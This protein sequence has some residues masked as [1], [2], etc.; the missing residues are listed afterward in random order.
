MKSEW[1]CEREEN[2]L[3]ASASEMHFMNLSSSSTHKSRDFL[4]K[5]DISEEYLAIKNRLEK[6]YANDFAE[7]EKLL[8]YLTQLTDFS[9]GRFLIKN[10][11][12]L[13][14]YWTYYAI[15]GFAYEEQLHSLEEKIL[16]VSPV[17]CATRERFGIFQRLFERNMK[18]NAVW[19][20]VPCGVMA[21]FLTLMIPEDIQN[22]YFVGMDFDAAA[23]QM[24]KGMAE[25][26]DLGEKC[27]F[28][29]RDAW[30]LNEENAFDLL[31]S[32]GLNI[33]E[34]NDDR[35]IELYRQ[36]YKT[37]KNGGK[38]IGSGLSCPPNK[39][40]ECEWAMENIDSAAL[41]F[42]QDILFKILQASW[43]NFRTSALTV[44]Q[45][46]AAGFKDISLYWDTARMFY[47]FEAV[48]P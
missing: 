5:S 26:Y 17:I 7:K 28:F 8:N 43:A 32:N 6:E 19:C 38:F 46:E 23:L 41:A 36:F 48:K 4:D 27:Q 10:H 22:L 45:L 11:G 16:L 24:A 3:Y 35:V 37:L 33:Y 15:Q 30:S 18:N 1:G 25:E 13:S 29:E 9:F 20:S 40:E 31:T 42:Q 44:K 2:Q 34:K 12:A 47:S 21:D 39:G 14:G